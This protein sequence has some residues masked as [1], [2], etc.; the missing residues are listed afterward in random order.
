MRDVLG[1][2]A[3]L[4]VTLLLLSTVTGGTWPPLLV[5]ESSSMMYPQDDTPYGRYG[6]I[7]VGDIVIIKAI[8]DPVRDVRTWADAE[9]NNFGRPGDVIVYAPFG[10]AGN[11][12]VIH[13]AMAY[14]EVANLAN[15]ST[16]Y[17][18][19]WLD[20]RVLTFGSA[21]IY[22]PALGFSEA[23]GYTPT[24]GY[25]PSYSG[26]LT[27]GDNP[28]TNPISD[29]AAGL[30]AIVDPSWVQGQAIV[31]IPWIGLGRLAL[32]S[33]Q[34]NPVVN[35][36]QRV[37]NGFAPLELWT[38]FFLIV[39]MIIFIPLTWDTW[40]IYRAYRRRRAE[41][42]AEEE[43]ARKRQDERVDFEVLT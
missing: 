20:G 30:S 4:I 43:A 24:S 32:Q 13:R 40:R 8:D 3:I 29:Q 23:Y 38:I 16:Q 31:E 1:G 17:K 2:I 7:D 37:G 5:I 11:T 14:V 26:F 28:I 10:D 22:L 42:A 19:H 41:L 15:G 21:G 9:S 33:G 36:W 25:R 27:K 39:A 35:G 34:T 6:T 12:S 18:V